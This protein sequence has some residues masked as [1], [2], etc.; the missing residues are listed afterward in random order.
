MIDESLRVMS[1]AEMDNVERLAERRL[2]EARSQPPDPEIAARVAAYLRRPY[3]MEVRGDPEQGYLAS[4]PEL[5]GCI[6]AAETPEAAMVALRD[7]MASWIETALID[8]AP[9]PE[10]NDIPEGRFNGRMLLR[11]P[12]TLHRTL[13]EQAE[14]DDVSVNHLAVALIAAGLERERMQ[15]F[16]DVEKALTTNGVAPGPELELRRMLRA[17]LVAL[18]RG[19]QWDPSKDTPGSTVAAMMNAYLRFIGSLPPELRADMARRLSALLESSSTDPM[20]GGMSGG[21]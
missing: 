15:F 19:E 9:V 13:A 7:A 8:G 11:L 4:A 21:R 16:A 2:K 20:N 5:P 12:K 1:D 14:R 3:R 18:A 17:F 6:T 10:P